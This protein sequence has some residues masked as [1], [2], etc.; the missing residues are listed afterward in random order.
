MIFTVVL[1][2]TAMS[3]PELPPKMTR[4]RVDELE[5]FA[6][7]KAPAGAVVLDAAEV[8]ELVEAYRG[9]HRRCASCGFERCEHLS[10]PACAG[11]SE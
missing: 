6:R 5:R 2:S 8:V 4:G 3:K 1:Q 11:F 9:H 10:S 7:L